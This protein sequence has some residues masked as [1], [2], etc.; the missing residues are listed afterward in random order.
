MDGDI[1]RATF[2]TCGKMWN[3][4]VTISVSVMVG[5]MYLSIY[6]SHFINT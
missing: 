3:I 5:K 6:F 2:I 4:F 1:T